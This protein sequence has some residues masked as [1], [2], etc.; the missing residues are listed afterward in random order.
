MEQPWA[1]K[2]SDKQAVYVLPKNNNT[3]IIAYKPKFDD[4]EKKNLYFPFQ[5][6]TNVANN[7]K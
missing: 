1:I 6:W 3:Q 2:D 7:N 4:N 5:N